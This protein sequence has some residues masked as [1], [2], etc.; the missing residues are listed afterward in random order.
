MKEKDPLGLENIKILA[1]IDAAKRE[2]NSELREN[3]IVAG[4]EMLR[5]ILSEVFSGLFTRSSGKKQVK[6]GGS[7]RLG[8]G[9]ADG[10]KYNA[11]N[12]RELR[13]KKRRRA[14]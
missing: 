3:L 4:V 2:R 14:C 5:V 8:P 11:E 10:S 7:G 13:N 6:S 12:Y 1:E 9:K